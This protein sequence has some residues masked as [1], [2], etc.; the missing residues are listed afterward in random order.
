MKWPLIIETE[1]EE[2]AFE[3]QGGLPLVTGQ[4]Q[5]HAPPPRDPRVPVARD[6]MAGNAGKRPG[7]VEQVL[8]EADQRLGSSAALQE[9]VSGLVKLHLEGM[10]RMEQRM[11]SME[12][13]VADLKQRGEG[14]RR[15]A[16]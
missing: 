15:E 7:A 8:T 16:G 13:S 10:E 3:A 12:E 2:R 6:A 5:R 11:R 4:V 1:G 9:I 14:K